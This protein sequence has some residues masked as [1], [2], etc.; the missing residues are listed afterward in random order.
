MVVKRSGAIK[1]GAKKSMQLYKVTK[2]CVDIESKLVCSVKTKRQPVKS[3]IN[4]FI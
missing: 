1:H 3:Q 2:I 4:R